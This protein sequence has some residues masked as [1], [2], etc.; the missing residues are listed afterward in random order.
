MFCIYVLRVKKTTTYRRKG[1]AM[2]TWA[3]TVYVVRYENGNVILM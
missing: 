3:R 2:H 1:T